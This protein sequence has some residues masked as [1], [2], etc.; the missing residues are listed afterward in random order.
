MPGIDGTEVRVGVTGNL[1]VAPIGTAGPTDTSAAWPVAWVDLGYLSEDGFVITPQ[2]DKQDIM[3][4]QSLASIRTILTSRS[5]EL[6]F[7]LM[8]TNAD[9]L[10]LAFG[11]GSVTTSGTTYHYTAP[12]AG[13][14]DERAFGVEV[15][16]ALLIYRFHFPRGLV[17][18]V[19]DIA[20]VRKDAV[21][22]E[23]TA[24]VMSVDDVTPLFD[25]YTNDANFA[26]S[27]VAA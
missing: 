5:E 24:T 16:D 1:K 23:L 12:L 20:F 27:L 14:V 19:G 25:F 13:D 18:D 11:G 6:K 2:S 15:R 17:T 10:K 4:W 9:T 21:K 3:V 7:T 26:A 22:Y 8:Q